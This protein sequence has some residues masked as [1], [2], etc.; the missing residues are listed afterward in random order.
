LL[1]RFASTR[2]WQQLAPGH[3]LENKLDYIG[4]IGWLA[5]F[6]GGNEAALI[7][8]SQV[9][10][11]M[12][13][14]EVRGE[15]IRPRLALIA[16]THSSPDDL[17]KVIENRLPELARKIYG[18][19]IKESSQ[20]SGVTIT[21][22]ASEN[23][24]R[25][26]FSAQ[27]GGE[28]ILANHSDTLRGCIDTRL[29][30]SPSMANNFHLQNSK[31]DIARNGVLFGFITGE[32][33]TR[34][35][36]F[37]IFMLSSNA[38]RETGITETLQDVF[39]DLASRS[40]DGMAFGTSF[41]NGA[42]VDRY[43]LLFKPDLVESLKPVIKPN[44]S[45]PQSLNL[46]PATAK[47]VTVINVENPGKTLDGI[48]SAISARIGVGQSFLLHQ[49]LLGARQ[50]FFGLKSDDGLQSALGNEISNF[51]VEE[52]SGKRVW[53]IAAR[54]RGLL[55]RAVEQYLSLQGAKIRR[56]NYS[57]IE[58]ISSSDA[59]KGS[60]IFIGNFLA[61]GERNQLIRLIEAQRNGQSLASA[62]QFT[63]AG[64]PSKDA[65]VISFS[66]VKDES[67]ELMAALARWLGARQSIERGATAFDQLPLAVS[68]TS[69][70]QQGV[71]VESHSPFGNFPFYVS[72]V[73]GAAGN[74]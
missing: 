45:D 26:L 53:L 48:E 28:W 47:D 14:L 51:V 52:E 63:T 65:A 6:T 5:S 39:S 67:E 11:V 21:S 23:P 59:R 25:R 30:R 8:R 55:S 29:G 41:E 66:S 57:G 18:R 70:K 12:T 20:Y 43:A 64:R 56:E 33:M 50:T 54:D 31:P 62:P 34:L 16:E 42:V 73:D 1:D 4:K 22:Y 44:R 35:L 71:Y 3:G 2:A 49:F 60:A 58:M 17:R 40:S 15:E 9:A 38:L 36:R 24:A 74:K 7:A 10:I 61:L 72:L 19:E 68:A 27:I 37:G 69:L 13:G 32:G 46:T